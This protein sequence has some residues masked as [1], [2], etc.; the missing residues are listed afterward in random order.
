MDIFAYF[1]LYRRLSGGEWTYILD[2]RIG[3]YHWVPTWWL[4]RNRW[5]GEYEVIECECW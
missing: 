3:L 5:F 1:K 4:A 2:S